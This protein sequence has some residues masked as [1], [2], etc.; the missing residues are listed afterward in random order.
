MV[1]WTGRWILS[2][3][4]NENCGIHRVNEANEKRH[5]L[6][7]MLKVRDY[8]F[9]FYQWLEQMVLKIHWHLESGAIGLK[10][11]CLLLF[12]KST[13]IFKMYMITWVLPIQSKFAK[14]KVLAKT[15]YANKSYQTD[16]TWATA[17]RKPL[18]TQL[19]FECFDFASTQDTRNSQARNAR[20]RNTRVN[21]YIIGQQASLSSENTPTLLPTIAPDN[22]QEGWRN[23]RWCSTFRDEFI[24]H[25]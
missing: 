19:F 22:N 14:A 7:V 24:I 23:W 11:N 4:N 3:S 18:F 20:R 15:L 5:I 8:V 9:H 25:S 21:W 10:Q 17:E 6:L 16:T 12:D 2:Q 13:W 1:V